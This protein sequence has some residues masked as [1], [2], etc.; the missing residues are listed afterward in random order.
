MMD[1]SDDNFGKYLIASIHQVQSGVLQSLEQ[2]D[3][4]QQN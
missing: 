2:V 3:F 1:Q 4:Q